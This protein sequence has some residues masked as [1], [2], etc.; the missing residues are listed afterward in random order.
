ME[1]MIERVIEAIAVAEKAW[2]HEPDNEYSLQETI[3]RAAIA[4]MEPTNA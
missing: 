1:E 4:A 2:W 3:A